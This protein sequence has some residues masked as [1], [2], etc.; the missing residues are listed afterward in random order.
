MYDKT[1]ILNA[2]R[3]LIIIVALLSQVNKT[4]AQ[5]D[6]SNPILKGCCPEAKARLDSIVNNAPYVFE[7]RVINADYKGY[8][9]QA[10]DAYLS[11]VF[12]IDKVYRGS[13]I[14]KG[15]TVEVITK[16]KDLY[17]ITGFGKEIWYLLLC[18]KSDI[19]GT[20]KDPNNKITLE[21]FYDIPNRYSSYFRGGLYSHV[22]PDGTFRKLNPWYSGLALDF[23]TKYTVKRFLDGYGLKPHNP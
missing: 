8:Q 16:P 17:G 4:N 6:F 22:K 21:L 3:G 23:K 12:E 7:A 18:K 1:A 5:Q 9:T 10:G 2:I 11:F 14:L 20:G 19:L 15:G 13:E